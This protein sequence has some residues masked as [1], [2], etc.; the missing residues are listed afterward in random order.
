MSVK[1]RMP[2]GRPVSL[3]EIE[4]IELTEFFTICIDN[5]MPEIIIPSAYEDE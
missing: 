2:L 5:P 4:R 1:N 3:M